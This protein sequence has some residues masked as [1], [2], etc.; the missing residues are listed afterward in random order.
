MPAFWFTRLSRFLSA[1]KM[2]TNAVA[3][4]ALL[5]ACASA[6]MAAD[7]PQLPKSPVPDGASTTS[8]S[9]PMVT[10]NPDGTFTVQKEPPNGNSKDAKA[11]NG[12]GIPPQVVTPIFSIP[13]KK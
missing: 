4:L 6:V 7:G 8:A 9:K 3:A 13:E 1:A 11:K 5:I 2:F 12:L 10:P